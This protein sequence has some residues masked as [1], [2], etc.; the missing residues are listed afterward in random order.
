MALW[1]LWNIQ[2]KCGKKYS[3]RRNMRNKNY[4]WWIAGLLALVAAI[5][6]LDRQNFPLVYSEIKETISI[7]DAQYGLLSSLFLLTYGTM[8][9]IGGRIVDILGSKIGFTIYVVWWSVSNILH[10]CVS[11]VLGLGI[12]RFLLGAG[13]GGSFPAAAKVISEW[14]PKKDRSTAFGL[15][16]TGSSLGAIIAPLAI[17]L[18]VDFCGSWKWTFII[19][20]IIGLLW[21]AIWMK[22]YTPPAKGQLPD[23]EVDD[24]SNGNVHANAVVMSRVKI[25]CRSLFKIRELWGLL[26]MKLLTDSAWFFF[27][28]WLPKYLNDMRGLDIGGIGLYAGIPY[29]FAAMGSSIGG[30][31]GSY[32]MKRNISLDVSRKITLGFSAAMLPASLFITSAST[33]LTAVLFLGIAMM[34]HQFWS[35][36][37]QTLAVDMFPSEIVGTISGL[38]GCIGTYGAMLFSLIVGIIIQ[39]YGYTPAFIISGLLHPISFVLLFLMIRKITLL[40]CSSSCT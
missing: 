3:C 13:E 29:V 10:S 7:S 19:F 33:V 24:F 37:M 15:F 8:Y 25:S 30:W 21:A 26:T 17:F 35:T 22:V 12:C 11:S 32:L 4:K 14:F 20:G 40:R 2:E 31:S 27:I 34:G 36:I 6:Y 28:F 5:N 16:N 9:A 23:N 18:I 39:D 1:M 38:M